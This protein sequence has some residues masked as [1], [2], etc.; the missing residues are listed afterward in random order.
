[1]Q[2][3][4][5]KN[6]T[7]LRISI[8]TLFFKKIIFALTVYV[9]LTV[10]VQNNMGSESDKQSQATMKIAMQFM[11]VMGKGD[12]EAMANLM[13][14]DMVWDNSGD[15]RLPWIGPWKGKQVILQE[16]FPTFSSNFQTK[17]WEPTDG[18]ANGN[19]AAFFGQMIGL[20]TTSGKETKPFTYAL[21]V[22]VKD[23]KVIL[24]NWFEDSYEVSQAYHKQ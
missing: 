21:R 1:M 18:F 6:T 23:G 7:F 22:K 11:D 5:P 13:H 15:Q 19:T 14:D 4:F 20:L 9:D 10:I 2:P 3:S 12:M 24:W 16:F 8:T 17:K